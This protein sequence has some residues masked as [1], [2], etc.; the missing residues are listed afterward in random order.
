MENG[1]LKRTL[2]LMIEANSSDEELIE[3][4]QK[5]SIDV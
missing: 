3:K 2:S 1:R 5:F 4:K